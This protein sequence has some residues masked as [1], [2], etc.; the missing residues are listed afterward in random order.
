MERLESLSIGGHS[1]AVWPLCDPRLLTLDLDRRCSRGRERCAKLGLRDARRRLPKNFWS[2]WGNNRSLHSRID[3]HT[4][5]THLFRSYSNDRPGH[6]AVGDC[7]RFGKAG[8]HNNQ[9]RKECSA[10]KSEIAK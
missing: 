2:R 7:F 8:S 10:D 1:L 3:V 4:W 5:R 6:V 9:E